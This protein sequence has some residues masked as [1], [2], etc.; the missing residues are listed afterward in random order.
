VDLTRDPGDDGGELVKDIVH[1]LELGL[2]ISTSRV[3]H[4]VVVLLH[5]YL[6]ELMPAPLVAREDVELLAEL[7][8][9]E[10]G[11]EVINERKDV[12]DHLLWQLQQW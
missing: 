5:A 11:W 1:L 12:Y 3:A 6:E 4:L 2:E 8:A 10:E 7:G 9:A